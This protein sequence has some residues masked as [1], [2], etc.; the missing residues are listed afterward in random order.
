MANLRNDVKGPDGKVGFSGRECIAKLVARSEKEGTQTGYYMNAQLAQYNGS[1]AAKGNAQSQPQLAKAHEFKT[2]AGEPGKSYD[3]RITKDQYDG[4][5]A[6]SKNFKLDDKTVIAGFKA[7]LMK[8]TENGILPKFDT[9]VPTTSKAF[10]DKAWQAQVAATAGA[11]TKGAAA[12]EAAKT[13][14]V[15]AEA[16]APEMEAEA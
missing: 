7:D 13:A 9:V 12:R 11:Y 14:G 10:N 4:I 6:K 1:P 3:V 5:V 2:A 8:S 15:T 16:P